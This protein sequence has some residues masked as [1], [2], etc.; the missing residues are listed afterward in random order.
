MSIEKEE[1]ITFIIVAIILAFSLS[2]LK[3]LQV[4]STALLI[5][6][7]ILFTNLLAKKAAAY[8]LDTEVQMKIWYMDRYGFKPHKHFKRPLPMGIILP[9]MLALASLGKLFW[10]AVAICDV[11]PQVYRAAKRHG[12]YSF[13]EVTDLHLGIIAAA[14]ILANIVVAAIAYFLNFPEFSRISIYYACF[15]LIPFSD[16]DGNKIFFGNIIL[17]SFTAII[18]LIALVYAIALV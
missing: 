18:A 9:V 12:I 14:G 1:I 16:L 3:P 8:L 13:S 17:W 5:V 4:F 6:I 10:L 2:F 15:N 7:I 11:K